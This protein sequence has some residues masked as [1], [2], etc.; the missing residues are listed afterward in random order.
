MEKFWSWFWKLFGAA[1]AAALVI[2]IILGIVWNSAKFVYQA[3]QTVFIVGIGICGL[4][5]MIV[6]PIEL[7]VTDR[8]NRAKNA[9]GTG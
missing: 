5:G 2:N 4:I 1:M 6:V 3:V 9:S 8:I 7:Y